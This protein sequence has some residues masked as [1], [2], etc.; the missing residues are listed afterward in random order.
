MRELATEQLAASDHERV[1]VLRDL[2]DEVAAATT[3]ILNGPT[4]SEIGTR[5]FDQSDA[6]DRWRLWNLA[7][8]IPAEQR[9]SRTYRG[10]PELI[11]HIFVS[12]ALLDPLP[13]VRSIVD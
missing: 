6:G 11:D 8:L 3:Q 7:P 12:H 4:G 5:G 1:V 13:E 10:R 2:N 9:Y